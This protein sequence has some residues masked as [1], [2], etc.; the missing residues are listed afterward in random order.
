M[1]LDFRIGNNKQ[2]IPCV[3][4]AV[5]SSSSSS[6]STSALLVNETIAVPAAS[7]L[8]SL[9]LLFRLLLPVR[10]SR[11]KEEGG[12]S[13]DGDDDNGE[14]T[15]RVFFT[16][17]PARR[18]ERLGDDGDKEQQHC[19]LASTNGRSKSSSSGSSS[20]DDDK[21]DDDND[22][23]ATEQ[24]LFTRSDKRRSSAKPC[25]KTR[26]RNSSIFF[27]SARCDFWRWIRSPARI[28]ALLV[29]FDALPH[30]DM[31]CISC[32]FNRKVGTIKRS[33]MSASAPCQYQRCFHVEQRNGVAQTVLE[34]KVL[35]DIPLNNNS[36]S[37]S[38][39]KST[40]IG[41]RSSNGSGNSGD[42]VT[43]LFCGINLV[44]RLDTSEERDPIATALTNRTAEGVGFAAAA[45]EST[46]K[47]LFDEVCA[48]VARDLVTVS[49]SKALSEWVCQPIRMG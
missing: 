29:K 25:I 5:S 16:R 46:N 14:S 15:T 43:T 30:L 34:F 36:S 3:S 42:V 9:Q 20:S 37:A 19:A 28:Q 11:A 39:P 24:P 35:F 21:D 44:P 18:R 1:S 6:S 49:S 41:G 33:A 31:Q 38:A 7:S 22:R 23:N 17:M 47:A 8:S 12:D 27:D 32:S 4:R 2:W 48:L 40:D 45:F 10:S 13:E 26:L